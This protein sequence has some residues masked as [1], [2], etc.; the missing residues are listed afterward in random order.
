MRS[1]G[2]APNERFGLMFA[3][4]NK[5]GTTYVPTGERTNDVFWQTLIGGINSK[6]EDE[7]SVWR[8][9]F[10]QWFAFTLV[11]IRSNFRTEKRQSRNTLITA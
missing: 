10:Q 5:L 8:D 1:S 3:L 6:S 11:N 4:L 9:R 2:S 7:L